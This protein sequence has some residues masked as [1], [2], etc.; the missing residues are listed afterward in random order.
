MVRKGGFTE[1]IKGQ[2]REKQEDDLE[3]ALGESSSGR[4][5]RGGRGSYLREVRDRLESW[6]AEIVAMEASLSPLDAHVREEWGIRIEKLKQMV[7]DAYTRL[8]EL[9][10]GVEAS[11]VAWDKAVAGA[12]TLLRYL[13]ETMEEARRTFPGSPDHGNP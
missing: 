1:R 5:V 13:G 3:E 7:S 11:E 10:R 12:R 2:L 6:N 9:R 4:G 8:E